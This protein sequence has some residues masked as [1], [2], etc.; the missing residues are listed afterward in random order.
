MQAMT[1]SPASAMIARN[2]LRGKFR[3][4]EAR[5]NGP[6]GRS[7]AAGDGPGGREGPPGP[8]P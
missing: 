4:E 2:I 7:L 6:R 5:I 3:S 1:Y 8:S